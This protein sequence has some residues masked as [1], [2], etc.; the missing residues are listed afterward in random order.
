MFTYLGAMPSKKNAPYAL[1]EKNKHTKVLPKLSLVELSAILARAQGIVAVD[2]GLGHLAAALDIPTVSLYGPTNPRL[3][4]TAGASQT[5]LHAEF[6]CAPCLQRKCTYT[7][8]SNQKPA[9]FTQLNPA[10][11]WD[12]LKQEMAEVNH[13][14]AES[15]L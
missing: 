7:G 5:H 13:Q 11:V 2:T 4:G 14:T 6:E 12:K 9:C 10:F 15:E 8:K 1:L 3:T